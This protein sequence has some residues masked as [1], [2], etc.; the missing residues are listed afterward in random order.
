[1]RM[2]VTRRRMA[3]VSAAVGPGVDAQRLSGF[4]GRGFGGG[5][6]AEPRRERSSRY[7]H[8]VKPGDI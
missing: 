5:C 1:M 3:L 8:H 6:C 4:G 2:K 7:G